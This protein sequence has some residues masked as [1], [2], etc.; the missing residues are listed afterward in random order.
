MT[1][2]YGQNIKSVEFDLS[3]YALLKFLKHR[4]DWNAKSILPKILRKF[5]DIKFLSLTLSGYMTLEST[6]KI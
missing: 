3:R 4:I 1:S 5:D 2:K 6:Q